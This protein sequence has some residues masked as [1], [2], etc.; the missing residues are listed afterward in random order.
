MWGN[1]AP[2]GKIEL[3]GRLEIGYVWFDLP[4]NGFWSDLTTTLDLRVMNNQ[5]VFELND[6][7]VM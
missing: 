2:C 4:L 3:E 6:I 1:T 7:H 5:L